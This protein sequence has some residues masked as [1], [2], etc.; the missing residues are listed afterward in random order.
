MQITG[1]F[2]DRAKKRAKQRSCWYLRY[3]TP[4]TNK[5]GTIVLQASGAPVLQRHRPFYE[6][7][8]AAEADIPRI[9][10]QHGTAGAGEFLFD[11]A[12]AAD[13]EA[14]LKITGGV[15]LA[16]VAKF[17]RLHHPETEKKKLGALFHDFLDDVKRRLGEER[18][19]SDLKSRGGAFVRSFG[20]RYPET[21]TRDQIMN[22]L[23][24]LKDAAPRTVRNHKTAICE[25]FGWLLE[26]SR[27]QHNPAAGIR[28]RM[29]PREE[30]KEIEFL[31]LD[32]ARN[33]LRAAE[34]YAPDLIAHE[35][36]QLL[37]GVRAD[38]EMADF[39][40]E[41]VHQDNREV[42]IPASVA[43]TGA[44]EVITELEE[45]FWDWW[46]AYGP[47]AGLLRP[48]NFGPKWDRLRVLAS[49]PEQARADE[50]A[51]MPIKHLLR[52]PASKAIIENWPW[53]ARRRTFCTFH[54]AKY[55]NASKT[56]LILRHRGSA[57]TLHNSYRGL[58]VTQQQGREY[59]E[60]RPQ[61]TS[62]KI[63]PVPSIRGAAVQ[64][65]SAE[66]A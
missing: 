59:F 57:Y 44:R 41:F 51:K 47:K 62:V 14:A 42:V 3:T 18:H 21:V 24:G 63:L 56:A 12:A 30:K 60:L 66:T 55:Q 53:N 35:I 54:V 58:G 28:K 16:T 10:E 13:Y 5:D 36:I 2:L 49:I 43:K 11:R 23:G 19:W 48:K 31:S 37:A 15:P 7:K 1:P 65:A 32:A 29:L 52:M 4:K 61:P 6:T 33:Y 34:R 40:A 25:F 20:D 8:A 17:W 27:I 50:L 46:S 22:Y 45:N 9:L 26:C 38:D 64:R 39:R